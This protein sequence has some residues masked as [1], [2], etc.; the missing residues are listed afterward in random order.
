MPLRADD[1]LGQF[2]ERVAL[3]SGWRVLH[4]P[5][6][7]STMDLAREAARRGWPD[8]SVF[9]ADYQ[10]RGRGR[11]GRVWLC[12][13]RGGLLTSY[14]LRRREAPPYTYTM[15]VAVAYCEAIERLLALEPAIK[16]P[17]DLMIDGRKVAG[18]LAEATSD[19][20]EQT[21][22]IGVGVNVNLEPDELTDVPNATALAIEAGVPV[23]RGE[24]QA[25]VIERLDSWLQQDRYLKTDGLWQAWNGRLWG[26]DQQV[27]VHEGQEQLRG[28][29]LGGDRDGT[30]LVRLADGSTR[31]IV[32]GE[33]LP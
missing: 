19:G 20:R 3:P 31:R 11:Q 9:V 14:L 1:Q 7:E 32:A 6:V 10:T 13:P 5:S 12:P 30:L 29:V 15:L 21:V 24:L 17:N 4:E 25:L 2:L 26:C 27:R 28:T 33:L 16:W 23:H 18:A 22:V 8:R